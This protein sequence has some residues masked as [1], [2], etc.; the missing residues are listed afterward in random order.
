MS[1]AAAA[2]PSESSGSYYKK[3]F[4]VH[5][6]RPKVFNG[7]PFK[8]KK[9]AE[10][11]KAY[12]MIN[13]SVYNTES[14]K[15]AFTLSFLTEGSATAWASTCYQKAF[16]KEAEGETECFGTIAEFWEDFKEAFKVSDSKNKAIA[17]L[18]T[19]QVSKNLTLNEYISQFKNNV[20][21]SGITNNDALIGYF[22]AGIYPH[23]THHIYGTDTPPEDIKGWYTKAMF[24]IMQ[25]EKANAVA[26]H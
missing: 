21:L 20:A 18:C 9:W 14:Q 17:W 15:I 19:A 7:T 4:E 1:G 3:R 16:D 24:F 2:P 23:L 11:V 5:L 12:L 25:R 22:S 8:A 26:A 10:T 6:G 13:N